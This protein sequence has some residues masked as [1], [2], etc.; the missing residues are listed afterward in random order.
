MRKLCHRGGSSFRVKEIK[1]R[2]GT[3][4][5]H[6]DDSGW[7]NSRLHWKMHPNLGESMGAAR[8]PRMNWKLLTWMASSSSFLAEAC[9]SSSVTEHQKPRTSLSRGLAGIPVQSPIHRE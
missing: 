8:D 6:Q 7:A 1:S 2:M 9:P 4:D 3:P 5:S